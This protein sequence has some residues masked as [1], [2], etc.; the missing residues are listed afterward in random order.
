M[1]KAIIVLGLIVCIITCISGCNV[2]IIDTVWKYDTAIT[3]WPDGSTKVIKIHS[4]RDYE[5]EQIQITG[6]DGTVYLLNS[7]NTVLIRSR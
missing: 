7:V 1:K 6:E 3:R 2:D 5:G 4:W